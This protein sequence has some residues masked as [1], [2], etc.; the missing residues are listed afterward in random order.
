MGKS[1]ING[2]FYGV[3]MGIIYGIYVEV[4]SGKRLQF[5]IEAMAI[6]IID[7]PINSMVIFHIYIYTLLGGLEHGFYFSI[8]LG[9]S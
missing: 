2:D 7:L 1:P 8:Q 6:E 4:A 3:L 9:M 5:A